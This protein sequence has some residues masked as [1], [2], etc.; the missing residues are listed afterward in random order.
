MGARVRLPRDSAFTMK[1]T[2]FLI[3]RRALFL[4]TCT[5]GCLLPL[6]RSGESNLCTNSTLN[7]Y[8]TLNFLFFF[9]LFPLL[10]LS[11]IFF[12]VNVIYIST[13]FTFQSV[14]SV[15]YIET[16]HCFLEFSLFFVIFFIS[17]FVIATHV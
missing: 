16:N 9:A 10:F 15:S 12:L 8:Q 17:V 11:R 5:V 14:K 4:C 7:A 6:Y 13:L 3:F 2:K 1:H